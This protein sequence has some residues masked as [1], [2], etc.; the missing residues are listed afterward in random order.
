[1]KIVQNINESDFD[2]VDNIVYCSIRKTAK[3]GKFCIFTNV[4]SIEISDIS[5]NDEGTN[6]FVDEIIEIIDVRMEKKEDN[7]FIMKEIVG[8][9]EFL[10]SD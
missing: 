1:M 8:I 10:Q 2:K 6:M 5:P 7:A 3:P 9:L 4:G